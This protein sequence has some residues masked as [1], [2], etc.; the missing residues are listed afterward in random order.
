MDK[1]AADWAEVEQQAAL[2]DPS[3]GAENDFEVILAYDMVNEKLLKDRLA[4][5][6]L[7]INARDQASKN[8]ARANLEYEKKHSYSPEEKSMVIEQ[9]IATICEY[10]AA[11][12]ELMKVLQ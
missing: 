2:Y 1:Y 10:K 9:L 7:L 8:L 3:K 4:K 5:M 11:E 12:T 6:T